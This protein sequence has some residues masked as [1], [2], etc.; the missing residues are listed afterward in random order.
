VTVRVVCLPYAGGGSY[1]FSRVGPVAGAELVKVD[2]PGHMA[3]IDEP[4]ASSL[5]G[6]ADQLGRELAA[7]WDEP[8]VLFGISL[9]AVLAYEIALRAEAEGRR[10]TAL[11]AASSL[12]PGAGSWRTSHLDDDG[13]IDAQGD[14]YESDIREAMAHPELRALLLPVVRGD[15]AILER[16]EPTGKR[17][18]CDVVAIVGQ[19]DRTMDFDQ[20]HRWQE[21]TTGDTTVVGSPGGH[22]FPETHPAA[23]NDLLARIVAQLAPPLEGR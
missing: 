12:A 15:L 22:F 1:A 7:V 11:V 10:P 14:R 4:L 13:F 21:F 2:Y 9:G 8:V 20:A 5:E 16:Y 19:Q 3:R 23:I 17:L 6:L 18:S